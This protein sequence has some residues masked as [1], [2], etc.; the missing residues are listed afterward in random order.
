MSSVALFSNGFQTLA[1]KEFYA[2]LSIKDH[3]MLGPQNSCVCGDTVK[4]LDPPL[5][6]LPAAAQGFFENRLFQKIGLKCSKRF[7]EFIIYS[8][9]N[10][11]AFYNKITTQTGEGMQRSNV[12]PILI[13][14]RMDSCFRFNLIILNYATE[15]MPWTVSNPLF[16]MA[17]RRE[18]HFTLS[19]IYLSLIA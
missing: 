4:S 10:T 19:N 18:L 8:A 5:K 7:Q 17:F 1:L 15:R 16:Q 6:P 9:A 13:G 12:L 14:N 3:L 11:P 2:D